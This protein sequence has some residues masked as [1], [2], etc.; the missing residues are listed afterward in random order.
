MKINNLK[1]LWLSYPFGA[2]LLAFYSP[3]ITHF[4]SRFTADG[5]ID[6]PLQLWLLW[7]Y[8][9]LSFFI[10]FITTKASNPRQLKKAFTHPVYRW[11]HASTAFI[12]ISSLLIK[13]DFY[14]LGW[15]DKEDGFFENI[16]AILF[17]LSSILASTLAIKKRQVKSWFWTFLCMSLF[18]FWVF[19]E[20]ISYGQ[21]IFQIETLPFLHTYNVQNENNLHNMLGPSVFILENYFL[22]GLA[23]ALT[24]YKQTNTLLKKIGFYP[25]LTA[26]DASMSLCLFLAACLSFFVFL[27]SEPS[28]QSLAVFLIAFCMAKWKQLKT[29]TPSL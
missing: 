12:V 2:L 5:H 7:P 16:T 25:L 28:E 14:A 15:L 6:T 9:S 1:I 27:G 8:L 18:A 20:E 11:A 4:L 29:S 13:Y 21:R 26:P 24:A 23:I 17:A 19:L 22:I 3:N 10:V